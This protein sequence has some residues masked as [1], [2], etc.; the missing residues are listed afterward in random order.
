MSV[1]SFLHPSGNTS[2]NQASITAPAPGALSSQ[3]LA[4]NNIN[5]RFIFLPQVREITLDFVDFGGHENF[6]VN[7]STLDTRE[8]TALPAVVNGVNVTVTSTPI[9]NAGGVQIGKQGKLHMQGQIGE[10][11]VGG[12]EFAIDNVCGVK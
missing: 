5:L 8:L 11:V 1:E 3:S 10:F 7:R 4:V 2:F 9:V 6:S 12:Q